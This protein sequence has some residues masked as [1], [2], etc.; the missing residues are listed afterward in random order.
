[1]NV[2]DSIWA[3]KLKRSP[4]EVIKKFETRFCAR[5]NQ[6]LHGIELFETRAPV[7]QW[8]LVRMMLILKLGDSDVFEVKAR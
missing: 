3:F 7:V 1:M 4:D 5:G 6:Q 2:I 8:T